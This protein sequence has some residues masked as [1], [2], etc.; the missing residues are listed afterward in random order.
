LDAVP[1]LVI[2]T[3]ICASGLWQLKQT[4]PQAICLM[5]LLWCLLL[6]VFHILFFSTLEKQRCKHQNKVLFSKKG[7]NG[8]VFLLLLL[9]FVYRF[10]SIRMIISPMTMI[11]IMAPAPMPNRHVSIIDAGVGVESG[12]AAGAYSTVMLVSAE[13]S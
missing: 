10:R 4:H 1:S 12:V 2:A 13:D 8:F 5:L 11:A 3:Q 6:R 7:G 9:L